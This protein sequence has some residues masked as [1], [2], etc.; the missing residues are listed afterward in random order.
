MAKALQAFRDG[1]GD[2]W[3][4][5]GALVVADALDDMRILR[6]VAEGM[7]GVKRGKGKD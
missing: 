4:F 2:D 5:S 3:D 1:T 6:M 7:A